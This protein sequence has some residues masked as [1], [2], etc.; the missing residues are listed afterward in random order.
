MADIMSIFSSFLVII[1]VV[2]QTKASD[3]CLDATV[4]YQFDIVC[5]YSY[6]SI[7]SI[8]CSDCFC[9]VSD[10]ICGLTYS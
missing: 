5:Y 2:R 10:G 6:K 1:F 8:L 9:V 3:T 7:F 4:Y